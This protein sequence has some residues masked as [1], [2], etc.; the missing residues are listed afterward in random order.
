MLQL[1][2]FLKRR[3]L[4]GPK[5]FKL[6]SLPSGL[7]YDQSTGDLIINLNNQQKFIITSEGVKHKEEDQ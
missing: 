7:L 4:P 2:K 5:N 6:P 1:A 3:A